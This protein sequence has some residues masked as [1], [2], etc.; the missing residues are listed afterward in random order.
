MSSVSASEVRHVV[1][2]F[3]DLVVARIMATGASREELIEAVER[4]QAEDGRPVDVEGAS[5]RVL[6]LIAMLRDEWS[7]EEAEEEATA[8]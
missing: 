5:K 8:L 2:D 3:D 1:G 6:D 7:E 4:A